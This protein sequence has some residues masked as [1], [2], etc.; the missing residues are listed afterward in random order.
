MRGSVRILKIYHVNYRT[1]TNEV[2][3]SACI[4]RCVKHF[5]LGIDCVFALCF[6][7]PLGD[8]MCYM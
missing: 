5:A 3:V 8:V 4:Y 2:E 1:L 7:H 6:G